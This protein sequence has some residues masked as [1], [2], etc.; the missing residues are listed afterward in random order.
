MS[1]ARKAIGNP[2]EAANHLLKAARGRLL[3]HLNGLYQKPNSERLVDESWDV[4]VVLDAC[5][6]DVLNIENPWNVECCDVVSQESNTGPWFEYNFLDIPQK[7]AR[8]IVYVTANPR[9]NKSKTG[10]NWFGHLE[11]THEYA[12]DSDIGTVH[13]DDLTDAAL[14]M[15]DAYPDRRLVAHYVQPHGPLAGSDDPFLSRDFYRRLQ[16][17]DVSREYTIEIYSQSLQY[18]LKEVDRLVSHVNG[19]VV[20]TSDHGE[21]FGEGGLYGHP[22]GAKS[23][24]LLQVP[25]IELKGEGEPI[26]QSVLEHRDERET[27]EVEERLRD[28]GYK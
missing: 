11:E 7:R 8:D 22:P 2:R 20:V 9:V 6:Y 25:W 15:H 17:G 19:D 4:L 18:A 21:S 24:Y 26:P 16:Q 13:P 3:V 14:R 1:R 12:W 5:R 10:S 28:L 23:K 27:V